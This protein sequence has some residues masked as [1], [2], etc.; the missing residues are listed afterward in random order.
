MNISRVMKKLKIIIPFHFFL[1]R[2]EEKKDVNRRDKVFRLI[3][4]LVNNEKG[5][6]KERSETRLEKIN[7]VSTSIAARRSY[8]TICL[9][10]RTFVKSNS[11]PCVPNDSSVK[12]SRLFKNGGHRD[13]AVLLI[14]IVFEIS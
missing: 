12:R 1:S 13:I 4:Q 11:S 5:K 10:E 2:I 9:L 3:V 14:K 7:P 8:F 6:R